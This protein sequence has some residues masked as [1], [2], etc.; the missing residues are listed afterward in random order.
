MI[1]KWEEGVRRNREDNG[2]TKGWEKEMEIGCKR[3]K[4]RD[5]E[6]DSGMKKSKGRKEKEGWRD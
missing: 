2:E 6:E 1:R 3:K 4:E 5:K